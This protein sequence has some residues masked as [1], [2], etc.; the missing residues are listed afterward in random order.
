MCRIQMHIE[1]I[2]RMR[3]R[4]RGDILGMSFRFFYITRVTLSSIQYV[5]KMSMYVPTS[6]KASFESRVRHTSISCKLLHFVKKTDVEVHYKSL[7]VRQN[8]LKIILRQAHS[9][10]LSTYKKFCLQYIFKCTL[11]VRF[12]H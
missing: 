1:R 10:D 11:S 7:D 9:P 3:W 5:Q 6:P 2:S 12:W 8:P 4:T